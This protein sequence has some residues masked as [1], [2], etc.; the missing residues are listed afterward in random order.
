MGSRI[1]SGPPSR[2]NDN[3]IFVSLV[4]RVIEAVRRGKAIG[5]SVTIDDQSLMR[6]FDA[7]ISGHVMFSSS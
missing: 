3:W 6:V 4:L 7:G 5:I 2:D 1:S